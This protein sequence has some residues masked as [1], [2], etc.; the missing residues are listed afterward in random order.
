MTRKK[1]GRPRQAAASMRS[2][3][4][5]TG[6]APVQAARAS[7]LA[8]GVHSGSA[9]C[10]LARSK[11]AAANSRLQSKAGAGN[12][13]RFLLGRNRLEVQQA[14]LSVRAQANH[15]RTL[16]RRVHVIRNRV[17]AIDTGQIL[18][19]SRDTRNAPAAENRRSECASAAPPGQG[20]FSNSPG[21]VETHGA[22]K[23]ILEK[24]FGFSSPVRDR[25]TI[26]RNPRPPFRRQPIRKPSSNSCPA[27]PHPNAMPSK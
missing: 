20:E 21:R 17:Q 4:A 26:G 8:S 13:R 12:S 23:S 18:R 10:H 15:A 14:A 1:T 11:P 22:K 5:V 9:G 27:A 3:E 16:Q 2:A 25:K 24:E 19:S 7:Q 6:S